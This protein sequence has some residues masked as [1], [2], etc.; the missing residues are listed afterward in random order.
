MQTLPLLVP[1]M[2]SAARLLPYLEQIDRN[3]HYTNFGPLNDR[4]EQRLLEA[5]APTR[6]PLHATT[7]SNCTV[8]LE[9]ALQSLDLAPGAKVLIPGITFAATATAVVRAGLQPVIGDVARGTWVLTPD[10][11]QRALSEHA[12]AAVMPVSTFGHAHAPGEW[13]AFAERTGLPV[14]IDAAGAYG[15]QEAGE[16][17]DVVYSFHATKS[18]GAAEGGA[19]LSTNA[20][21]I[22]RIRRLANFGLDTSIGQL[23]ELGTNGKMSEYHAAIGLATFD[24]WP[25]IRQARIELHRAYL[26]ELAAQCPRV[27]TQDRAVDGIYPL[28]TVL[29][30]EGVSAASAVESLAAAGIQSRRWYSPSLHLHPALRGSARMAS[31]EVA[32]DIGERLLGIPFF[33]GLEAPAR[34]RVI[35]ALNAAIDA[36]SGA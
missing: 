3:A 1:S 31:L 21:R 11:A 27:R 13:D 9:L 29:L 33:I 22:A 34:A 6:Q 15:N 14:V 12:V 19:V 8:A 5:A 30:P 23:V 10:I 7:L 2:P 4:F 28:L 26:D 24:E 36:Q 17:T 32:I 16:R 18:F 35:A 20:E 25:R